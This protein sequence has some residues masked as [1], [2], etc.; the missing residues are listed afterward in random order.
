MILGEH[1]SADESAHDLLAEAERLAGEG[2]LREAIR[3]GYIAVLCDLAD[4]K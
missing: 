1:V 2:R 3:K 4:R